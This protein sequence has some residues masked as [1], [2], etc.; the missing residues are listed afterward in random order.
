MELRLV[1]SQD[2]KEILAIY[3]PYI[4][5]TVITFEYDIPSLEEFTNRVVTI[6]K[7]MPY[8]V[9]TNNNEIIGYGYASLYRERRAYAWAVE[10]S[11]YVD[12]TKKQR[13]V[14][15]KIY[16]AILGLLKELGYCRVY[17]CVTYP[18]PPSI[19]FH[20]KYGFQEIGVF[21]KAGYKFG[22]WFDIL[23][24]ELDIDPK[25][26]NIKIPKAIQDL[27][28]KQIEKYLL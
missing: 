3:A 10:L 13:G 22:K 1:T 14:G 21:H 17:S 5:E 11:I 6:S 8:I 16:D 23:W 2:S 20:T 18:N 9:A 7:N 28:K 25:D 19:A 12:N 26:K 24:L 4:K 27:K 15:T